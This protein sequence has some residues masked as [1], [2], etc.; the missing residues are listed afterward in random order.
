MSVVLSGLL[1]VLLNLVL[2]RGSHKPRLLRSLESNY[3]V[4]LAQLALSLIVFLLLWLVMGIVW[5]M[6]GIGRPIGWPWIDNFYVR[7]SAGSA[8]E[9]VAGMMLQFAW[10]IFVTL[11]TYRIVSDCLTSVS[12]SEI[13]RRVL[14]MASLYVGC[15]SFDLVA[16]VFGL[17]PLPQPLAVFAAIVALAVSVRIASLATTQIE[18]NQ[19]GPVLSQILTTLVAGALVQR[20]LEHGSVHGLPLSYAATFRNFTVSAPGVMT[21]LSLGVLGLVTF[22]PKSSSIACW[23]GRPLQRSR[24]RRRR[25]SIDRRFIAGLVCIAKRT[26]QWNCY[27][28]SLV[29]VQGST[30][31]RS[32]RLV[33]KT[34]T[35]GRGP[36]NS[37]VIEGDPTVSTLHATVRLRQN[38]RYEITDCRSANGL[39]ING[40]PALT[41][42]LSSG[43]EL[44]VG[45]TRLR[46]VMTRSGFPGR[47]NVRPAATV[48]RKSDTGSRF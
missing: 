7:F 21:L 34:V 37:I 11:A 32:F 22:L 26:F 40:K 10:L 46:F 13:G 3:S 39:F 18:P 2:L 25:F 33:A 41:R 9:A 35:I 44:L 42:F 38:G 16:C 14:S 19:W 27:E 1:C 20:L 12:R 15:A 8:V 31:G 36:T 5:L 4:E 24:G 47:P 29:V 48:G 17:G 6:P 45:D 30:Q 28:A 43:D 23:G